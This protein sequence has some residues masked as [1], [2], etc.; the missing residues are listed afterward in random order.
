MITRGDVGYDGGRTVRLIQQHLL[1]LLIAN[2]PRQPPTLWIIHSSQ[3]LVLQRNIPLF[4]SRRP[5]FLFIP[6][7][8]TPMALDFKTSHTGQFSLLCARHF[9]VQALTCGRPWTA[10]MTS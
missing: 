10:L 3:C 4:H 7:A 2:K 8:P 1:P 5:M 9:N 6:P